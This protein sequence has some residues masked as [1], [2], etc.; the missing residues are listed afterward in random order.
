MHPVDLSVTINGIHFRSPLLTASGTAGYGDILFQSPSYPPSLGG[1]VTKGISL[2][3]RKG[4]PPP[5][6]FET[7][8]G[9]LN[10]IG[11]ENIGLTSFLRTVVP[12]LKKTKIPF[13]VNIFGEKIDE[14]CE[15]SET[16][17]DVPE[18]AALELNVSCPNVKAGGISFGKDEKLLR[19]VVESVKRSSAKPLWV[20][21]TPNV[22]DIAAL[23]QVA[24][25]A[26][27]DVLTIANSYPGLAVNC[28]NERFELGNITGGLTGPAVKPLTLFAVREVV[29]A[30]RL[31][32]IAAGGV[33][34]A[35]DALEY[36]LIG[37]HAVQIGTAALV[38]PGIFDEIYEGMEGFLR[39]KGMHSLR[40]WIGRLS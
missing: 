39:D 13:I 23:A 36:L 30:T 18:I 3:P 10:A 6:I 29:R 12:H 38:N 33:W 20:K 35:M 40:Q 26:G 1:F 16:L 25:S 15:I 31:P 32:V 37:A 19:E 34:T 11:L 21:L 14:L 2:R 4:N 22:T 27:A 5:R 17:S 7:P 8:C 9:L 28:L 24:D